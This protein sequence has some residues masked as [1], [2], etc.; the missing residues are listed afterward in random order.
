ML[1]MF[2]KYKPYLTNTIKLDFNTKMLPMNTTG[3]NISTT[4]IIT[5]K[6]N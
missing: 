6:C 4:V 3:V 2:L 1:L 5:S